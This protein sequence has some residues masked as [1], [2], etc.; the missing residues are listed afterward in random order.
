[1][2]FVVV[3]VSV[4]SLSGF[5]IVMLAFFTFSFVWKLVMCPLMFAVLMVGICVSV[6][7]SVMFGVTATVV[8][9][10]WWFGAV[11][12]ILMLSVRVFFVSVVGL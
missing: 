6:W 4:E 10:G 5:F 7:L 1:M 8:E 12:S 9:S 3:L 2:V 11:K